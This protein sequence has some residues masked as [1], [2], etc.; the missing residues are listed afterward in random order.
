MSIY[1]FL[2]N[3]IIIVAFGLMGLGILLSMRSKTGSD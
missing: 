1:D 2:A 3:I